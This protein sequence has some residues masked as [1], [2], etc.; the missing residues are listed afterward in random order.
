MGS[1]AVAGLTWR[2]LPLRAT[3]GEA[4]ATPYSSTRARGQASPIPGTEQV[5]PIRTA[6]AR[7]EDVR[8]TL[9][10]LGTVS[11]RHS[12]TVKSRV[13]G[14]L[15]KVHFKEGDVVE[16]GQLLAEIDPR[17]F[18]AALLRAEGQLAH[19]RALLE[20]AR[21]DLLRYEALGRERIAKQEEVEIRR[22]L[23]RQYEGT[24]QADEAAHQLAA[25]E[26]S[27]SRITA[28][29]SGLIGFRKVDAGN[30]VRLDDPEGLA[31]INAVRP[32]AVLFS[33]PEDNLATL[34]TRFGEARKNGRPLTVEAWDKA[35]DRLLATGAVISID[36][37]IDK[38]TGT[39]QLK[40]E[41]PNQDAALFP[42]QFVNVRLLLEVRSSLV[43]PQ[44]AVQRGS[45]GPFAW[46]VTPSKTAAL[47]PVELGPVDG[48][49][50]TIQAGLHADDTVVTSGM[51]RLREG[52]RVA[53]Q[54]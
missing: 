39:I 17:P 23:V 4:H 13:S 18:Q 52:A 19:D 10:A 29:I 48:S 35:H 36:N 42:N 40:A 47:R 34:L 3:A 2:F 30:N 8:I 51:D 16:R 6:R 11:P 22:S 46:T 41:F 7:V 1:L 50:V 9:D 27:F 44:A 31:V 45:S 5:T 43:V 14:Q 15:L 32:I 12:V 26:L 28:P 53:I 33:V 20:N 49:R 54:P 37:Q 21:L 38:A 24:L 25:L